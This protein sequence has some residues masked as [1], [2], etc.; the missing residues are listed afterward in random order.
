MLASVDLTNSIGSC[1]FCSALQIIFTPENSGRPPV[2]TSV[3]VVTTWSPYDGGGLVMVSLINL[4]PPSPSLC[5]ILRLQQ[6]LHLFSWSPS[7]P[8]WSPSPPSW[9]PSTPNWPPF[10]PS[11]S[12]YTPSWSPHRQSPQQPSQARPPWRHSGLRPN[13]H[14]LRSTHPAHPSNIK[15]QIWKITNIEYHKYWLTDKQVSPASFK[16][17]KDYK[18]CILAKN[19]QSSNQWINQ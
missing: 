10:P 18:F 5:L 15:V 9:S 12:P 13:I 16:N 3:Q 8:S 11:W 4:H 6:C 17:H 19:C 7:T 2:T 1:K 14:L